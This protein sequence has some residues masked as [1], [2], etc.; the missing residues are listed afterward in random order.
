[1]RT[2]SAYLEHRDQELYSSLLGETILL[3]EGV[4]DMIKS[5]FQKVMGKRETPDMILKKIRDY[6]KIIKTT[7]NICNILCSKSMHSNIKHLI[8]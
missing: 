7:L 6:S 8:R 2:F 4:A 3:D 5:V 1:M